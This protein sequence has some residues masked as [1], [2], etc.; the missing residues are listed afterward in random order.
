MISTSLRKKA[1]EQGF[2]VNKTMIEMITDLFP[3]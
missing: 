3:E 1:N 2:P